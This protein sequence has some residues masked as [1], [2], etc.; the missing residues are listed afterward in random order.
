LTDA[1][2]LATLQAVRILV[3]YRAALR[4]R[5]GVGEY[6][7]E[8]VRAYTRLPEASGD[9]VGVFT[10]SWKDRP[11]QGLAQE[12]G[13]DVIDRR[14]PVRLLNYMWHRAE[15]PPVELLAGPADVVHAQHPLLIPARR[16]AH[17][18]T[19]HDLFF[20]TTPERTRAEIRRDYAALA[21]AHA[22][23][24]DAIVVSS[25]YTAHLVADRLDVP[26]DRIHVCPAGAPPWLPTR[27]ESGQSQLRVG[28]ESG[29]SQS[30]VGSESTPSRVR[31]ISESVQSGV[32]V[33]SDRGYVLFL[34]TLEPRKNIGVLLDA[35]AQLIQ[36]RV[37]VPRL[38]LAGRATP[39]AA[40]WLERAG[41]APLAGHVEHRGYVPASEREA[42]YAGARLVVMPS[43]DE[44]FGLP[45]LE[46]MA[47]GVPVV[48][49]NRGSLP[50]V[51][52][53]AAVLLE[54]TDVDGF[55]GAIERILEDDGYARDLAG[56][57]L[58]RAACFSWEQTARAARR[59]YEDA[60]A[61]R[62]QRN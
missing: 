40:D 3:D 52:G 10:S 41:R 17:V 57:G 42:L 24:A 33:D 31:V 27:S 21:P 4:E 55:A 9:E 11:R 23:R 14:V 50:E 7:H 29:Q 44:G 60:I 61:R 43:L 16:A 15:W 58:A 22:R 49:S 1:K 38:I 37:A 6:V 62:R 19:I 39:E 25:E 8:L 28:S 53:N 5:S 30:R 2:G 45:V 20:L 56:R 35:Y 59:A 54:A 32:G 12:L 51:A 34:G 48:A 18:I 47:A 13:A 26:R 46:A 36:R